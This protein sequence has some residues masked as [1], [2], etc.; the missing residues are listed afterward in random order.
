MV[1]VITISSFL[2]VDK[3]VFR[4]Q[5]LGK[6]L[7]KYIRKILNNFGSGRLMINWPLLWFG[8]VCS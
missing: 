8:T 2:V 1:G 7:G 6:V 3:M 4:K 5:S